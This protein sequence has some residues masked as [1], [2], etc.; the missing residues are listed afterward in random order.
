[1]TAKIAKIVTTVHVSKEDLPPIQSWNTSTFQANRIQV[2]LYEDRS[3]AQVSGRGGSYQP[4]SNTAR[5]TLRGDTKYGPAP[6][7]LLKL[8]ADLGVP[9]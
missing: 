6:S 2:T 3:D 7:E 5:F 9:F 8:L 1:M 4:G